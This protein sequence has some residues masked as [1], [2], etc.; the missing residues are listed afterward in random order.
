MAVCLPP[1]NPPSHS[2]EPGHSDFLMSK[3]QRLSGPG[4]RK[5]LNACASYSWKQEEFSHWKEENSSIIFSTKYVSRQRPTK[6]T[7]SVRRDERTTHIAPSLA[8]LI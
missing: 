3:L 6:G 7:N 2:P 8:L 4:R 5:N 1:S